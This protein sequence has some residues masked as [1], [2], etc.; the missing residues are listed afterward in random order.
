MRPISESTHLP[1]IFINSHPVQYF[2]PL[3]RYLSTSGFR[4]ACW[5]CSDENVRGHLDQ[6]FGTNVRWDIP[7]LDGYASR[8]FRNWS[9]K[10]SLYNGFFGLLNPG[11]LGALM[12]EKKSVVIVPGWS[13]FSYVAALILAR[14]SGHVVCLRGESPLNQELL[15]SRANRS[16]KRVLLSWVLFPFVSKFLYIGKQNRAFYQ[17]FGV[18]E[19]R[20][21]FT[22]YAVDNDRFR[23][24]AR[25]YAG[26]RENLRK[27]LG[28]PADGRMILFAAKFIEKK[29]PLDLL[30]AYPRLSR[31]DIFLVMVG[32][33]N[34]KNDMAALIEARSLKNVFLTGFVNQLD[35]VKYY[36]AADVFVLCSGLGET[37]GLSV[38]EAMNFNLP[39]VVSDI[40]GCA[41]DLVLKGETGFMSIAGDVENLTTAIGKALEMKEVRSVAHI[42]HYSFAKIAEAFQNNLCPIE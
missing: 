29:R 18:N 28:L 22:P 38:N 31:E 24:A 1:V 23:D 36:A 35:I 2:A 26:R 16:M 8:F 4:I 42:D 21:V 6:Q 27:E 9:W 30:M 17:H 15:K 39:V 14:L 34:L 3:Y 20:L 12:K 32:D 7:L 33:G 5:Y 11:M 25:S 13:Y 37:W 19:R 40:P 10:P 41:E